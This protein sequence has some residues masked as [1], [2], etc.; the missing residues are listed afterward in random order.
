MTSAKKK[1]GHTIF[2]IFSVCRFEI[3][4]GRGR[5]IYPWRKGVLMAPN[6][7]KDSDVQTD[8]Q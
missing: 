1:L 5:G 6:G 2:Y 3:G 8:R 7:R 4:K